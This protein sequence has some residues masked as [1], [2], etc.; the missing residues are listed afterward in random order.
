M[1]KQYFK[2]ILQEIEED[3]YELGT[4]KKYVSQILIIIIITSVTLSLIFS[5][6]TAISFLFGMLIFL[7]AD[8]L[9]WV[10]TEEKRVVQHK[11]FIDEIIENVDN[12]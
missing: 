5:L 12:K 7:I 8:F 1:M 9:W 6:P 4:I 3:L 10:L 11:D 2:E